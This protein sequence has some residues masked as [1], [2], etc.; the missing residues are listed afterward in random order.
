MCELI[1]HAQNTRNPVLFGTPKSAKVQTSNGRRRSGLCDGIEMVT[2]SEICGRTSNIQHRTSNI[3]HPTGAGGVDQATTST[4]EPHPAPRR[5]FDVRCS[6]AKRAPGHHLN[7]VSRSRRLLPFDVRCSMLNV[8]CSAANRAPGHHLNHVSSSRCL[9]PFDVRCSMLNVRCSAAKRAPGHHLNHVSPSRCLLPFD[10][11]C[12]MLNVRCSAANRASGHHL[13]P[14]SSSRCL[15]PFDVRC[16]M[17]NVRCCLP[18]SMPR[19][20][21]PYVPTIPASLPFDVRCSAANLA[22]GHHLKDA[23]RSTPPPALPTPVPPRAPSSGRPASASAS[24]FGAALDGEHALVAGLLESLHDAMP[25]D[26][27]VAA[28]AAD[29]RAGDLAAFGAGLLRR[30]VLGVDVDDLVDDRF[31]HRVGIFA[32][33]ERVAAIVVHANPRRIHQVENPRERLDL[34]GVRPVL[35]DRDIDAVLLAGLGDG[36]QVDSS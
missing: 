12:S 10:V 23:A 9:L 29:G 19:S 21:S 7:H 27:A 14:V 33:Q 11:R 22:A 31:E 17:L 34:R 1:F 3:Q 20:P 35:L 2:G 30:D 5:A 4:N 8:R 16:S 6:A 26:L 36:P 32:G 15:L 13:N 25:V 18:P 28:G 24:F